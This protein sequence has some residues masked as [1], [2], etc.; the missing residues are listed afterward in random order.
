M[1]V[2]RFLKDI[3]IDRQCGSVRFINLLL[4]YIFNQHSGQANVC[5][6]ID[7]QSMSVSM[8]QARFT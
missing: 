8:G 4:S 1:N 7:R 3:Y 5:I 6:L 2:S